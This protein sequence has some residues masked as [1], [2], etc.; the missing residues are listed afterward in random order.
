ML[1]E[2]SKHDRISL[3]G[4]ELAK[5]EWHNFL[6]GTCILQILA[7]DPVVL[8]IYQLI[9][10]KKEKGKNS[11]HKIGVFSYAYFCNLNN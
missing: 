4:V 3:A 11:Q 9:V 8:K 10:K 2:K 7:N 6:I 1:M 5:S